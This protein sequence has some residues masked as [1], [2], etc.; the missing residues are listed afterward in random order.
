MSTTTKE[1]TIQVI[2]PASG[3]VISEI[4]STT[5]LEVVETVNKAK[6]AFL[7]W[8]S[9]S[10]EKRISYLKTIY[11]II[12][13][14]RQYIAET[15][16]KNNGKP[17]A[18]AYLTEIAS[19]LQI[20]EHFI[21]NGASL[22]HEKNIPL[23]P[24][25]PTK[26]SI[27]SYEPHGVVAIVKPWNYPFY[28]PL[29]AITKA[30]LAG[31]TII[32]K[33]SSTVS[34]V[35][36]LIEEILLKANFP[37]GVVNVIYGSSEVAQTLLESNIDMVVFT[38]SAEVGKNVASLCIKKMLPMCLELGGKDPAIVLKSCNI[39]YAVNGVLWGA[40]ANA[41]QACASIERVY[42][43]SSIY[44]DFVSKISSQ[45]KELKIG[46]GSDDEVDVGPLINEE[47]LN[48]IEGHVFDAINKGAILNTGGKRVLES[49]YFF[50]PTVLSNVNHT[51]QVMKEET[52]GPIIPIMKFEV[53]EEVIGFAND[54]DYGL[55]ASIWTGELENLR[56]ITD[57]L[58]CGTVWVND[59]LFLQAHPACPWVGYKDSGY[60]SSS[61]YQFVKSKHISIDQGFIPGLRPKNFWWY[62]YKGKARSYFDLIELVYK[63][64]L[65][66]KAKAAFKTIVDF[67]K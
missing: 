11:D 25:Y 10:V 12:I 7:L 37:T 31:N 36:K 4:K 13:D 28:L 58:N 45:A 24:L 41:G 53:L 14:D 52:F 23:G 32:F 65:K 30:L 17:L 19:T 5:C 51:M 66:H 9:L 63:T 46:N 55:S 8:K 48:K 21:K 60:G 3:E 47:Q 34:L 57:N 61:I 22:L 33:P 43:E 18:E 56:K 40:I 6:D 1:N 49:G 39:D 42:V 15:I 54:T 67:L 38:G 59:S 27:L 2:N 44:D 62:P 26:K 64:N 35:G 16:T 20:M 50:E 29:S